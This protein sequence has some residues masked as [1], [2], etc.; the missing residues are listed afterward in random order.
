MIATQLRLWTVDEYHHMLTA[1]I[2][3]AADRV[4][5][6]DGQIIQI[7]PLIAASC[8]NGAAN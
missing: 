5:L 1:G 7:S 4:E 2:L 6:L 8:W 3:T